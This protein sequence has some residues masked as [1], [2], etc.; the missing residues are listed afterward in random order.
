M[1]FLAIGL[2]LKLDILTLDDTIRFS[3]IQL[4]PYKITAIP[5]KQVLR[6]QAGVAGVV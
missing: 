2:I 1:D 6:V 5:K 3:Y 4:H